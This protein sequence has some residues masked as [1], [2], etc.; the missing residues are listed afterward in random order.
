M[1]V[2]LLYHAN[3]YR[4]FK[5][6]YK[7]RLDLGTILWFKVVVSKQNVFMTKMSDVIHGSV[8]H[9][10]LSNWKSLRFDKNAPQDAHR[11]EWSRIRMRGNGG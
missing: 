9:L 3:F 6:K 7:I 4:G 5:K 2:S 10:F 11:C 1:T 8:W